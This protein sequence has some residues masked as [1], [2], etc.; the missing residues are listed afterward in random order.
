LDAQ[1]GHARTRSVV[2]H[3]RENHVTAPTRTQRRAGG[4]LSDSILSA[5]ALSKSYGESETAV[6]ALRDVSL[7]IEA[8][9]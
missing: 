1:S 3:E 8:V 4:T 6:H 7:E 9:G 2:H 5:V